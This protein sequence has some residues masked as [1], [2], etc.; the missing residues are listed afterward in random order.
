MDN[1]KKRLLVYSILLFII[2]V[3][4]GLAYWTIE[5]LKDQI[6]DEILSLSIKDIQSI[7]KNFPEFDFIY[8]NELNL[9]NSE[10]PNVY[11]QCFIGLRLTKNDG[12]AWH[13]SF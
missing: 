11:A 3:G 8:S 2:V 6:K 13:S 1:V 7:V 5:T 10:M 12:N 4:A 9:P